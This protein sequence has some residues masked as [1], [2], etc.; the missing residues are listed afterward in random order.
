[1]VNLLKYDVTLYRFLSF[2]RGRYQ[3]LPSIDMK[4]IECE[5][6]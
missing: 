6:L 2:I 3:Y 4:F 1:M 5:I